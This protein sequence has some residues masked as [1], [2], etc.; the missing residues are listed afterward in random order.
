[1]PSFALPSPKHARMSRILIV[2]DDP[3]A[4]NSIRS[5]LQSNS[6]EAHTAGERA[7]GSGEREKSTHDTVLL[8]IGLHRSGQSSQQKE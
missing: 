8:G 7:A 6:Q 5:K 3:A 2:E 1:V 4:R